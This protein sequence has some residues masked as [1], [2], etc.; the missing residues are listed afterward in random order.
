VKPPPSA[1]EGDPTS[2]AVFATGEKEKLEPAAASV[3]E[4][5]T[6]AI[7]EQDGQWLDENFPKDG[8][9]AGKKTLKRAQLREG[10]E[11][12]TG[13]RP[14]F[15]CEN[16]KTSTDCKWSYWRVEVKGKGEFWLYNTDDSFYG[17]WRS[18]VFKKKGGA[19]KWTAMADLDGGEP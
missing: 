10:F 11:D 1:P 9:Q 6:V 16:A 3:A 13:L 17:P 8:V 7:V 12:L 2:S 19:W 18:M 15:G 4:A 5:W 14:G